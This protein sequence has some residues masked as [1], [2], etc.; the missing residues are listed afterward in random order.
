MTR[1]AT[2]REIS[3][4]CKQLKLS[5]RILDHCEAVEDPK[6]EYFLFEVLRS[7]TEHR[8]RSRLVK[9]L[10]QAAF[11]YPKHL[12]DFDDRR[13]K[14]PASTSMA[15]L[16]SLRFIEQSQNVILYGSVGTGKTHLAIGLGYLACQQGFRAR[17]YTLADL[18]TQLSAAQREGRLERFMAG[19][20][21]LDLLILDE[22]GY[23]PVDRVGSQLLFRII[24]DCYERKSLILTTNL[25]F[26]AWTT[27]FTD[28][29]MAAA[30]IDRL[31]HHGHLIVCEG[32]SYRVTNAL[33]RNETVGGGADL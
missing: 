16:K 19:V 13:I 23:I 22:W 20:A 18:I 1:E 28:E 11:P 32:P 5:Q 29:Q 14:Y 17:F 30:L 12:D 7:E 8:D 10:N 27:I 24:S 15:E 25:E 3:A 33:M 4:M 21:R 26:S 31:V 9:Q 2:R 6:Q